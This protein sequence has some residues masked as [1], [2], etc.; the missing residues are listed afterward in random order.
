MG[1]ARLRQGRGPFPRAAPRVAREGAAAQRPPRV[2][3]VGREDAVLLAAA[4]VQR[5]A[6]RRPAAVHVAAV[7]AAGGE[8]VR[9]ARRDAP[10]GA[11][12]GAQ[13]RLEQRA[14]VPWER[15]K[16]EVDEQPVG[17]GRRGRGTGWGG[18]RVWGW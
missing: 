5:A 3:R 1:G 15:G 17:E 13:V 7:D 16:G 8:H 6:Q 12:V 11:R 4:H 14:D 18:G 9:P 10:L 2:D